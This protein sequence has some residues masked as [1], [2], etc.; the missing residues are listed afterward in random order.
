MG[1][2]EFNCTPNTPCICT[3]A[4]NSARFAYAQQPH[5][6]HKSSTNPMLSKVLI[7]TRMRK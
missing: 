4:V 3:N 1:L 2:Y 6:Q 7:P 5:R